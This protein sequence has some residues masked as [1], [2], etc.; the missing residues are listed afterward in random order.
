MVTPDSAVIW[1]LTERIWRRRQLVDLL[2]IYHRRLPL[3]GLKQGGSR[4]VRSQESGVLP[5]PVE[6][7]LGLPHPVSCRV[8][9]S[10]ID[11]RVCVMVVSETVLI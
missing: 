1:G 9:V 3:L 7:R 10:A 5:C 6:R 8:L 2:N 11:R 4:E